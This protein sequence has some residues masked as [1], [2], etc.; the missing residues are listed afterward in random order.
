MAP[1]VP[2]LN[3]H[4][5]GDVADVLGK[6]ERVERKG[7]RL[8]AVVRLSKR[9]GLDGLAQ[10]VAD[11]VIDAVSVGYSVSEWR[12]EE[13]EDGTIT[14]TA[15]RWTLMEVSA[16]PIPADP[17]ARVR[18]YDMS[19]RTKEETMQPETIE[20]RSDRRMDRREKRRVDMIRSL[21]ELGNATEFGEDHIER[22]TALEEFRTLLIN[23][24]ADEQERTQPRGGGSIGAD[25][26]VG[27]ANPEQRSV[28]MS[29]ALAARIDNT[30]APSPMAR[31]YVGLGLPELARA[32][33]AE[34]N[35]A[36]T[37]LGRSAIV[38]Q[39]LNTRGIG[40]LHA[41]SDF[42]TVLSGAVGMV[43]RRAYD[44]APSGLKP[45]ARQVH[46]DDFRARTFATMSGFSG[47]EKV[48]EHGE[49]KRGT[50][51]DSGESVRLETF[52]KVFGLTRQAII[53]DDLGAFAEMPRRLGIAAAAFEADQLASL[54]ASN[55]LMSDGK[56]LFSADHGNVASPASSLSKDALSAARKVM[57]G[58]RDDAGQLIGV[59]PKWLVVGPELE[60]AAEELMAAITPTE[61]GEV[62][63]IR[64]RI[65]VEPRLPG[66]AWYVAADPAEVD[67]LVFGHLA[68]EP[69]PVV[70]HRVGFDVDGLEIKVRLDFG[71]AFIDWRSWYRNAGSAS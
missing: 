19:D 54:L 66:F 11:G 44:A 7:N 31:R 25:M 49:F 4:R 15:A 56:A 63:P 70:E 68:S 21:A 59:G 71:A 8:D 16:V 10:D 41:T 14:K 20:T 60:T 52:G 69:G 23:H 40:G 57:R 29:E 26:Y 2:F 17:A 22:G 38:S 53:N 51:Q 65:A 46:L 12:T 55:P 3:S 43:L 5:A 18:S 48:G 42:S 9:S 58:Q 36:V 24:L 6:V 67:G 13:A 35:V 27:G 39:A 62:Q 64:L 45:I 28:A 61:T 33:L 34:N 37:G 1:S 32:F 50:I 30:I 47:L